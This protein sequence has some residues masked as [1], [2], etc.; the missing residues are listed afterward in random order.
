MALTVITISNA[1]MS[2]RG[3]LT[4]WMQEI[5]TGVYVGNL[6]SRVREELWERVTQSVGAGQATLSY[7]INNELGYQFATHRTK[8]VNVSFDGIPLVMLPRDESHLA[9]KLKPGFSNQAKLRKTRKYAGRKRP[10]T[11]SGGSSVPTSAFIVLDIETDGLNPFEDNIIEVAAL[12]VDSGAVEEFH[13]L[14]RNESELPAEIVDLTG[15][16][17][18]LLATE[19]RHNPDVLAELVDF[20]G[21][22]PIVGYNILF[23]MDF[24]NQKL[25]ELNQPVITNRKIDLLRLIKKEKMFLKSY[26]LEDALLAY[27]IDQ[28][29]SHRALSDAHLAY[30]LSVKVN[31]FR[32]KLEREFR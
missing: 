27:G 15:I 31:G 25:R 12:R 13:S 18:H 32:Q 10:N 22:L 8:Q 19:G 11:A 9:E 5:A 14:V 26:S 23:D 30:A 16:T 4:K 20:L 21:D 7:A 24:I 1:P 29:V 2:L 28:K 3:D 6:N 17:E